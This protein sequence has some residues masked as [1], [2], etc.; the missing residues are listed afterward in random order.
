MRIYAKKPMNITK[1]LYCD[2][3]NQDKTNDSGKH[4]CEFHGDWL[5]TDGPRTIKCEECVRQLLCAIR[6]NRKR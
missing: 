6:I 4:Y 5:D 2:S 3:C 1:S